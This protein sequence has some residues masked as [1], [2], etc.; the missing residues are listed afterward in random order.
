MTYITKYLSG[1]YVYIIYVYIYT[2]LLRIIGY[3]S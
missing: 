1:E 2:Y 3:A